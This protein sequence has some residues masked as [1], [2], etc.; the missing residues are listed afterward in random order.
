MKYIKKVRE[1]YN[2]LWN[3]RLKKFSRNKSFVIQQL[4]IFVLAIRGFIEDKIQLR[5]SALTFYSLLSIV[6]VL[7]MGF[8]MAKGLGYDDKLKQQLIDNFSG[9]ETVL[10][11]AIEFAENLI[12]NTSEGFLA[13][14]GAIVLFWSVMKVLGHIERSFNDIWQIK[15]TRNFFRKFSDYLALM[16]VAPI[17]FIG[18]STYTVWVTEKLNN[19]Q[20]MEYISWF[21]IFINKLVPYLILW[22]LFSL[23]YIIMPNT[24]VTFKNGIIAGIIA[25]TLFSLLQTVY[26]KFQFLMFSEKY[27]AIYGAFAALPL[28]LIWMQGSWL[29]VLFGAEISFAYQNVE[30]YEFEAESLNISN[31]FKRV[32]TLLILH[33]IIKSFENGDKPMTS[34]QICHKLDLPIRL[35][36]EIIFALKN[37]NLISETPTSSM[38]E[39]A[40]QPAVDINKVDIKFVHEKLEMF[41]ADN[42]S[43]ND[44]PVLNKILEIQSKFIE[45][46]DKS[47]YNKLLKDL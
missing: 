1:L 46:I 44:T 45:S 23:L 12:N 18:S 6:P 16:F 28:F 3:V 26:I 30:N 7:A 15:N 36:R 39:M 38:K 19:I 4:R 21:T 41:G 17:L 11:K 13:G 22:L 35:V 34:S 27:N 20:Y 24:K 33:I 29:I 40:Y 37:C 14:I 9:Q 5:A 47:S 2:N 32:L 31:F 43:I 25:G 10:T 8:A 42:I